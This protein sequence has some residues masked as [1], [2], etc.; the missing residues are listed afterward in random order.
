LER[1]RRETEVEVE[2]EMEIRSGTASQLK[3][4]TADG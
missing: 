4:K 3:Q 1:L 2:A